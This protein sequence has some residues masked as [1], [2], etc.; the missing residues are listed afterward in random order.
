[1]KISSGNIGIS[2]SPNAATLGF[3]YSWAIDCQRVWNP[4]T[5]GG[6]HAPAVISAAHFDTSLVTGD[7]GGW[8]FTRGASPGTGFT[9]TGFWNDDVVAGA[10]S[11]PASDANQ[12][13]ADA[14]DHIVNKYIT[15][16]ITF[17]AG[18]D[19]PDFSYLWL[20]R[21]GQTV[22]SLGVSN[23]VP[24]SHINGILI[25]TSVGTVI[26][27]SR[28]TTSGLKASDIGTRMSITWDVSRDSGM[29]QSEDL[30]A[31]L[32]YPTNSIQT[33]NMGYIMHGIIMGPEPVNYP[34]G[35]IPIDRA[36]I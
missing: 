8:K 31:I 27:S 11:V 16:V 10:T 20:R 23:I 22:G 9:T 4:G 33:Y 5:S 30:N 6:T 19:L 35:R 29:Q 1:M 14:Y 26:D 3:T 2:A 17:L 13:P 7:D 12:V 15:L 36:T 28:S 25:S 21:E 34:S 24:P 18:Y 32:Y